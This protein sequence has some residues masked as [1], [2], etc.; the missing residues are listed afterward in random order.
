MNP[1]VL[2]IAIIIGIITIFVKHPKKRHNDF[3][4]PLT[5][6]RKRCKEI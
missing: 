4:F 6:R 3:G 2:I 5:R 1:D